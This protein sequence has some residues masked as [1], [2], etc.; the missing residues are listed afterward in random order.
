MLIILAYELGFLEALFNYIFIIIEHFVFSCKFKLIMHTLNM[1]VLKC[2]LCAS[3]RNVFRIYGALQI[4]IIIKNVNATMAVFFRDLINWQRSLPSA[5]R[6][7]SHA[8]R[9]G[10]TPPPVPPG[11]PPSCVPSHNS[12]RC[13]SCFLLPLTLQILTRLANRN[14]TPPERHG[15][16]PGVL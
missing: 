3:K 13:V 1:Y 9:D 14:T 10:E 12:P 6:R 15:A 11:G 2:I 8:Q 16:L 7:F 4:K 5:S